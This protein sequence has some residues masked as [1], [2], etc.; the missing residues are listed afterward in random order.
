MG[1]D[2]GTS[3]TKGVLVDRAGGVVASRK[4]AHGV[5]TPRPGWFEQDADAVWWHDTCAVAQALLR[6]TGT[7][8]RAVA[9]VGVSAIGPCVLPVDNN[10]RPLRPGI[11]YGI[12][13]RSKQQVVELDARLGAEEVLR[14]GGNVLS[15]QAAGP[16]IRWLADNEPKIYARTERF[17]T[18]TSFLVEQLTGRAVIDHYTAAA[19]FTPLYDVAT[20]AWREDL[21]DVIV[22]PNR[23]PELAWPSDVAGQVTAEA[24]AATGLAQ[25]T[26]VVVGTTDA[27]AEA[28]SAG[29]LEPGDCMLMYGSTAFLIAV[30]ERRVADARLWSAP[31]LFAG[32]HARLGGMATTG[33][34]TNWFA[35]E[36][37]RDIAGSGET[38][39]LKELIAEA[40]AVSPGSDGLIVLPYFSGERTPIRDPDASGLILGLK[41]GHNRA[42]LFRAVLE[43]VAYGIR[44][45]LDVLAESSAAPRH[46]SAVGGG[47]KNLLWLQI[48]SDVTGLPQ[49]VPKV[50]LGASYGDAMLAALATGVADGREAV[51]TWVEDGFLVRPDE[52]RAEFYAHYYGAY[53]S[54]YEGTRSTMHALARMAGGVERPDSDSLNPN[55]GSQAPDR[56]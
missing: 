8:R 16:K 37:A 3:A 4:V 28:M 5:A 44:H 25:G 31:Y 20:E 19:G 10:G 6:E 21:A 45:H 47:T 36:L 33:A 7:D 23:L 50:S 2:V 17:H 38:A 51:A 22:G 54:A 43:G 53:R 35:R 15:T 9:A 27:A 49:Q 55:N 24:S 41:L 18:A 30:T 26:P 39:A 48:V 52:S 34:L 46:L 14:R 56:L 32:T 12:D 29:V 13:T 42:H 11:L 40:G 1:I